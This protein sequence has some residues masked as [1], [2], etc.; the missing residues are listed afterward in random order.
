ME[1]R[2]TAVERHPVRRRHNTQ[3][4]VLRPRKI[5]I[6]ATERVSGEMASIQGLIHRF[7]HRETI[8]ELFEIV[9]L[10]ALREYVKPY[11]EKAREERANEAVR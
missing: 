2:T 1:E 6:R 10:P 5:E 4:S 3:G 8:A 9:M 11:A 7:G